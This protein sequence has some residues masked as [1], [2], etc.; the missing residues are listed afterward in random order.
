MFS[1][2]FQYIIFID[3]SS[4]I[5]NFQKDDESLDDLDLCKT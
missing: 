4:A 3:F 5:T 2:N 1:F